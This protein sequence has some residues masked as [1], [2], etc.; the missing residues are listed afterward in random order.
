M[1]QRTDR[2]RRLRV[3]LGLVVAIALL[4]AACG[5]DDGPET[6]SP[7][8]PSI[9]PGATTTDGD[10]VPPVPDDAI[11]LTP[12]AEV[13]LP[14]AFAS[15][16]GTDDLYVA[17]QA[18]VVERIAVTAGGEEPSSPGGEGP[19][20]AL[21]DEP[22]LD[23][24]SLT[25]ARGE[26]GLLGLAFSPDGGLLY[27]D[28]TDRVG[29]THVVEY[30]MDGD[31]ADPASAREL[32]F[33]E[34][35]YTNHNGGQLAFG[36]DGMLY[37]GMGDGGSRGDP[38]DR[39]QDPDDLLG[40]ILRIDPTPA[41]DGTPYTIPPDNPFATG[42]GRPEIWMTGLRN[43]WRFGFDRAT[44]D[45]WVADVGQNEIEEVTW[46]PADPAGTGRC[47]NLGWPYLE[48]TQPFRG[49]PPTGVTL[50]DPIAEYDHG[51]GSCSVTGGYVYRGSAVPALE[52]VYVYGDYCSSELWGVAAAGGAVVASGA[53]GASVDA[54]TLSSF[55][56]G[57]DGELY[58]LSIEGTVY[59]IAPA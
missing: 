46:L 18:G 20:F 9:A 19:A 25:R 32:L 55:G 5:D 39:A 43:P 17:G 10:P 40:K 49:D 3:A 21:A 13:D 7:G 51:D 53:L 35:P 54:N 31:V 42:G 29:H 16:P 57:A 4:A 23:L 8:S 56:E 58:V 15:R 36:P 48:G 45:L 28:Y 33:I 11:R 47:A 6:T 59:R 14:V 37:V 38:E 50:V 30:R 52:G 27:V 22:V 24:S 2:P 44:G 1:T 41:D 34:Q 12:V 26:Q